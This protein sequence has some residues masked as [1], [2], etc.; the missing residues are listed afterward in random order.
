MK[1]FLIQIITEHRTDACSEI[2]QSIFETRRSPIIHKI[3]QRTDRTMI[4]IFNRR[5]RGDKFANFFIFTFALLI[6]KSNVF[7]VK[8]SDIFCRS[9]EKTTKSQRISLILSARLLML[10]L[11][12][13]TT[14]LLLSTNAFHYILLNFITSIIIHKYV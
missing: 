4:I 11:L 13:L 6:R 14:A 5:R 2:S 10:K 8:W 3:F 1:A 12:L 9:E 7:A